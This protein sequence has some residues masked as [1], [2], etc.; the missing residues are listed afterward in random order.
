[1]K[2]ESGIYPCGRRVLVRPDEIEETTESGL[3]VF[4][5][6]SDRERHEW[7][8][9]TG[10][11]VAIGPDC[12]THGVT[13]THHEGTTTTTKDGFSGPFAEV[14]QRVSFAPQGGRMQDGKDG[15]S[16]RMLNDTDIL[17]VVDEE[18]GFVSIPEARSP[19]GG[20]RG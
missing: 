4:G 3:I 1:M 6:D 16:Y 9:S 14:G 19:L 11:L 2:N 8:T 13:V 5:K 12:W 17:A 10:Y 7:G 20:Q 15:V 18:V